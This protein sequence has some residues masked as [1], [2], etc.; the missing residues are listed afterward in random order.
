[1]RR[2]R[3]FL[4]AGLLLVIG[5]AAVLFLFKDQLFGGGG[6]ASGTQALVETATP[7]PVPTT[8]VVVVVQKV[9]RGEELT[10]DKLDLVEYPNDLVWPNMFTD[11]EDVIG[12]VSRYDLEE[13]TVLTKSMLA[14]VVDTAQGSEAALFIEKGKVAVSIPVNRLSSVSYAPQRGDHVNVIVTL[15]LVDLDTSFQSKLPNWTGTILGAGWIGEERYMVPQPLAGNTPQGRV[16]VDP[17]FDGSFYIYPS[18][19]Q[20]PRLVSQ[21]LI[22]DVIV[23]QMGDFPTAGEEE[24][25]P[26][27][28]PLDLTPTPQ[29]GAGAP[30]AA[31]TT[32]PTPV[33]APP[34]VVT[35]IVSP[36]DAV[37]LNYLIFAGGELTLALRHPQDTNT[38]S[39]EAVTLQ[40]LLDQYS[41]PVPV[42]LPY[43]LE[44]RVDDLLWPTLPSDHPS[45]TPEQ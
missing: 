2:G 3:L 32:T 23:L 38:S 20:R 39:T 9:K 24:P 36:Q 40:F 13:Y 29:T 37:T 21:T 7:T 25:T 22:Q 4:F 12:L 8:K 5:L 33:P 30:P 34:D 31:A 6:Q 16:E 42:K 45:P 43:G 26:T 41:I 19:A 18:E 1:M 11:I 17:V 15:M 14:E 35:L 27:P 10:E 28:V 44:P